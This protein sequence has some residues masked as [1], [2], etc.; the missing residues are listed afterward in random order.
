MRTT[1]GTGAKRV[2][3]KPRYAVPQR[4]DELL[5]KFDYPEF[6]P[7]AAPFIP[8]GG[9]GM[10]TVTVAAA[11]ASDLS[12]SKADYQCLGADD[13]LTVQQAVDDIVSVGGIV[14]LSEGTFEFGWRSGGVTC[15]SM[16]GDGTSVI[17]LGN[18]NTIINV[19]GSPTAVDQPVFDSGHNGSTFG[20]FYII[21]NQSGT[22][23][24]IGVDIAG[25]YGLLYDYNAFMQGPA[26]RVG[27]TAFG[28]RLH[29]LVIDG[30]N[31]EGIRCEG[32]EWLSVANSVVASMGYAFHAIGGNV[33]SI[34]GGSFVGYGTDTII[35]VEPDN[36]VTVAGATVDG[37]LGGGHGVHF[38][39]ESCSLKGSTIIEAGA[40]VAN[41]Y[42]AI[43]IDGDANVAQGNTVIPHANTRYGLNVAAGN[44]NAV[45]F[46]M[47]GDSS[48]Y[49]TGD[50]NDAG[51]GTIITP[52]ANGQFTY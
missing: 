15:V 34:T 43:H 28:V 39:G 13:H 19:H 3:P 41:T 31:A 26:V 44:N 1:G 8:G 24:T 48:V 2:R 22:D 50:F 18:T 42:D 49:A 47:L 12:K 45:P 37:R 10:M 33:V 29:D 36:V 6:V 7:A 38:E 52:D 27:G 30:T 32:A 21:D 4:V 40:T 5:R 20:G 23:P 51:T 14:W 35:Y 25:S 17:G 9:G 46:N 16:Q 11:N